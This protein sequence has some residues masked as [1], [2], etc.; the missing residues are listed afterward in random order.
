MIYLRQALI[1]LTGTVRFT[2]I[3]WNIFCGRAIVLEIKNLFFFCGEQ[4]R[5]VGVEGNEGTPFR[6]YRT[7]ELIGLHI[8]TKSRNL[9]L[10]IRLGI[11]H[12]TYVNPVII[13]EY[14]AA[15]Y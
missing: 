6:R 5:I 1:Q 8:S 15:T 11:A 14:S 9:L 7:T 4:H 10:D 2:K 13:D 12:N 3:N